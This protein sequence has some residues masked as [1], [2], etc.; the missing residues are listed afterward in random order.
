MGAG[1][2]IEWWGTKFDFLGF[3]SKFFGAIMVK[4]ASFSVQMVEFVFKR[5]NLNS[6]GP[7]KS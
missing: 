2:F 6:N 5:L 3:F 4:T 7:I 1:V